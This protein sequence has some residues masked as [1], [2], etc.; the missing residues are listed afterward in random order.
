[1]EDCNVS[2]LCTHKKWSELRRYL[3][4]D[5]AEEEK[6]S[7]IMYRNRYGTCLHPACYHDTPDDIIK[8]MLDIGGKELVMKK[9]INDQTALHYACYNG[10]SYNIIKM[11]IEVGGKD[12]VMA[13]SERGSTA[14]LHLCWSIKKHTK[15]ANIIN[16]ILQVGDANL[17]LTSKDISG[18]TP[19]EIA[20]GASK[21]I[22]KLLTLQSK[23]N[24]TT[25]NT[26]LS[27]TIVPA[28]NSTPIAQSN[29][30]QDTTRSSCTNN[31]RK[32]P[33]RGLGIDQN[34]QSQLREANE[35]AK[36]IQKDFDQKCIDYSELEENLRSQLK[37]AKEQTLQIQHDYDQK[38][39]DCCH[40]EEENQVENTEKL[41]LGSALAL[42]KKELYTCKRMK[43][44]LEKKVGAQGAERISLL[45]EQ[46][47]NGEKDNK[48]WKK[49]VD[50]LMKICSQQKAKLH[51]GA[52][53]VSLMAEQKEKGEK[54]NKHWKDKA[55]N[56]M[57]ICSEYKAKLQEMKDKAGAPVADIQM[58][59]QEEEEETARAQELLEECNRGA[60]DLEATVETQ[61][62][63]N[64]ALSNKKDDIEKEYMDK[65]DKLT[66]QLSKQHAELQQLKKSSSE[67]EVGMKRKHN[68]EEHEEGEGTAV[69]Q[70]QTRTSKR[71]RVGNTRNALSDSLNSNQAEDDDAELKDMLMTRYLHTRQLQRA[72]ARIAQFEEEH[73]QKES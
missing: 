39:A 30:E 68:N 28:E 34:H 51:Q 72:N 62:L 66:R 55:D 41:E 22:K 40:L 37:E 57:Q 42:L 53:K 8:A 12:L 54:D 70:S 71:T 17:L 73:D 36:T 21:K 35:K 44:D 59:K 64:A 56:Y 61:R 52:E 49:K 6:K 14:L 13:K 7:K 23:S 20:T 46:K 25:S 16:I 9:D 24:S 26:S 67:V 48:C 58:I 4:S 19:L 27:A 11:L 31:D 1:M 69:A 2:Q 18:E 60:V 50:N 3:S 5:A 43:V 29:Q 10:A 38:C 47:E 45:A 15:A 32:I 63:E 65:V 33:I